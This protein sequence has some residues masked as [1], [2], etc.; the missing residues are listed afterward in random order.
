MIESLKKLQKTKLAT[1]SLSTQ[2]KDF[3]S[4]SFLFTEY[5]HMSTHLSGFQTIFRFFTSF[6]IRMSPALYVPHGSGPDAVGVFH[7]LVDV[8]G[9]DAGSEAVR[10]VIRTL[11][12]LI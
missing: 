3:I 2:H 7:G 1:T 10:C 6:C 9:D 4:S 5:S 8:V 12:D 11:N